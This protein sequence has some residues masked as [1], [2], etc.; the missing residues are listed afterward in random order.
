MLVDAMNA[1]EVEKASVKDLKELQPIMDR[2][3]SI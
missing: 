1:N 3:I 2:Y